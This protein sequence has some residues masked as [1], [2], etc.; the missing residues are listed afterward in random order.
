MDANYVE[1]AW[2]IAVILVIHYIISYDRVI[3]LIKQ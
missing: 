3:W 1:L 2:V